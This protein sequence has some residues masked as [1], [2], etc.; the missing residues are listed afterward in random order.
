MAWERKRGK[1]EE[2]NRLLAG[3]PATSFTLHE[4]DRTHLDGVRYVVTLDVDTVLPKG[5]L[6]RLVGTLAH[7]LNR[8]EFDEA[9]GRVR[10]GYTVLQPRVEISPECGNRSQFARWFTGDTAIDIYSRAVSDVY[11]DLFGSGIYVGKG[12]YDVEAFRRSLDG[13]VP[14]NALASHDL[15]E[16]IHGRAALATDIVLYE[17]FPRQYLE[18]ARRQHR[19]IRGDWQL[20]PWLGRS[21]PATGGRRLRNRL[22]WIDRWKIVDNLRRSLLP[23]A[24]VTML[25]AGWLILPGHPAV[26]TVLGVLAPS[27]LIFTD[28]VTGFAQGRRRSALAS[29]FQRLSDHAGRWLLL[30]V[31][32]PYDAAVAADAIARTVVRVFLT[33]RHLLQWTSAARTSEELAAGDTR[34]LHLAADADRSHSRRGGARRPR[35][36]SSPGAPRR[37]AAARHVVHGARGRVCPGPSAAAARTSA[38]RRRSR[39][40]A[41]DCPPHLAILRGLR[42]SGRSV[43]PSG[44]LSGTASR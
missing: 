4:G 8:A 19:W 41:K 10:S 34:R 36:G 39:S 12:A 40:A 28:L 1:L 13:R 20:L 16:G 3:D 29:T 43:A 18:F 5:A 2:F 26:W 42:R 11:Q 23:P 9:S 25:V 7:P 44:Q 33:R 15:F 21:V 22:A 17:T 14:E 31:F 32:L 6:A 38:G 24:L 35:D 27:G 37:V 30:L